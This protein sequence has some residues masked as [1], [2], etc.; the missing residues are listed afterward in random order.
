[1]SK[2][3]LTAQK[4]SKI[5]NDKKKLKKDDLVKLILSHAEGAAKCGFM[6]VHFD[7]RLHS[8]VMPEVIVIMKNQGFNIHERYGSVYIMWVD[9][10]GKAL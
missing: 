1:M 7:T 3:L 10:D 6:G 5:L 8:D 4:A 9:E 2:K